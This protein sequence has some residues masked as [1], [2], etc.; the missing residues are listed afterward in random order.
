MLDCWL[1]RFSMGA[2]GISYL[3]MGDQYWRGNWHAALN[4]YWSPLYGWLTGLMFR[5]TKPGIRWE[6]PEV[7][8]LNFVI[9]LAALASFEFFWRSML[10]SRTGNAWTG[11]SRL[12][13]WALGYLMFA[14][15]Y[16]GFGVKDS[17]GGE[18]LSI[19]TPDLLVAALAFLA[20]GLVLRFCAGRSGVGSSC[21][22]G[23]ALG[24]AYLAKSV[25]FPFGL[26]VMATLFAVC[27]KHRGGWLR[28]G[29]ALICFL[30]ISTTF[31]AAISWNNHHLTFG[32]S[33][34]LNIAW[35]VN[36][37]WPMRI[38]WQGLGAIPA[39]PLHPT[40]KLLNWPEVYEFGAPVA[41]TYP[42]WYDPTYWW[43]GADS[44]LHP[45]REIGRFMWSMED[46]ALYLVIP[47]GMLT[48]VVLLIFL[49][50]DRISDSL[51]QMIRFLPV[52]APTIAL[53]MMY[54]LVTWWPRYL[55]WA[56]LAGLCAL[57]ASTSISAEAQRVRVFR[58]ASLMLGVM[59]VAVLLQDFKGIRWQRGIWVQ[60]VEEAEQLR[61]MGIEPGN[62]VAVIGDGSVEGF[63]AR[64]DRVEIVAE[65]PHALETGDSATAFWNSGIE[66]EQAVLN[67]LKSTGAKAVVAETP[68][69]I[70][71][72]G[73]VPIGNT[74]HAVYFFH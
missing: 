39:H 45:G 33:G 53:V 22:L 20:F 60:F 34:K 66:G 74:G 58:A 49:F 27:W 70:L 47:A 54:A 68:P 43:A 51:R 41:G 13:A 19:V 8:L 69:K 29:A 16:F 67:I 73:W 57:I 7:H 59:L 35:R 25:M 38:H 50:S 9:F 37:A 28:A 52:L 48:A 10:K 44:K 21:L 65:V 4:A 63:W 15:L 6:Y 46:L 42:V 18:E 11:A 71:P 1:T 31:I 61:L 72:P 12:Y 3:D 2:D 26:V 36:G 64:L 14:I 40:R 62:R 56:F 55:T 24:V 32:D 5:L 23:V 30:A 17:L